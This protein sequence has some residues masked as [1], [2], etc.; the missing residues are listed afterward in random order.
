MYGSCACHECVGQKVT[1]GMSSLMT[2][3]LPLRQ[4]SSKPE[5]PYFCSTGQGAPGIQLSPPSSPRS[6]VTGVCSI[7]DLSGSGNAHSGA[8]L[9]NSTVP[10]ESPP[11]YFTGKKKKTHIAKV[12]LLPSTS[13][14][15]PTPHTQHTQLKTQ[16]S[17][18][19]KAYQRQPLIYDN[20]PKQHQQLLS[21]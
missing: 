14:V 13:Q 20:W 12:S 8:Q 4:S 17:M 5:V 16:K 18:L 19:P 10:T 6:G 1:T 15:E 21:I 3:C 2:F 9:C 7:L 11:S